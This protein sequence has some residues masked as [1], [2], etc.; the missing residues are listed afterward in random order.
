MDL[1]NPELLFP[2]NVRIKNKK[3]KERVRKNSC[4]VC[5]H[6]AYKLPHHIESVGS[7]G[8]DM[9]ENQIQLCQECHTKA[10]GGKIAKRFLFSIVAKRMK[11]DIDDLIDGVKQHCV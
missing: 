4:E 2:K 10:H 1:S 9:E 6:P 7:G 3:V 11:M 5:G 8:P